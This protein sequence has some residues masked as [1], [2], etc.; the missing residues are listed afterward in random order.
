MALRSITS[1]L[2]LGLALSSSAQTPDV[3]G[4][5]LRAW[6]KVHLY[7]TQFNDL[8]YNGAREQM[9]SFTDEINDSIFCIYTGFGQLSSVTTFPNPINAEHI[10]PQSYYGSVSPMRSD[11]HN[12]RPSHQS[13]NS[14]RGNLPFAE[15]DDNL[16]NWYGI[17][18]SG[19]YFSTST[20]PSEDPGFSE[21]IS[22]SWEPRE[23]RKGDVARQA[24]YFFTMYPHA[25]GDIT[26]IGSISDLLN[27]HL[28][29]PVDAIE[30][31]RNNRIEQVQGNRNPYIDDPLLAFRAWDYSQF[32]G[33]TY[34]EA[35]NYNPM[36]T[37]DDGS[38]FYETTCPT[39]LN[40]D[41]VIGTADLLN[42]LEGFG[43][44]CP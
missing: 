32:V 24:F 35:T 28:N 33:C 30:L 31:E 44:T 1:C 25:A 22:T 5:P 38:C 17:D 8:G 42:L 16:S 34:D 27:W 7:E 14:A 9:Y 13:P 29:D 36:A 3:N 41:G 43:T 19:N 40:G 21:R 23:D 37:E 26:V 18:G 39:D 20:Q 6:L 11:I 4:E 2:L 10:I 12:L 15:A